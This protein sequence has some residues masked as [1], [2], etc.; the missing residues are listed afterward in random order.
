LHDVEKGDANPKGFP[1]DQFEVQEIVSGIAPTVELVVIVADERGFHDIG[2]LIEVFLIGLHLAAV[3]AEL[4]VVGVGGKEV[5]VGEGIGILFLQI[6]GDFAELGELSGV[7]F[8]GEVIG[9]KCGMI[10]D[11]VDQSIELC[12]RIGVIEGIEAGDDRMKKQRAEAVF[13]GDVQFVLAAPDEIPSAFR[14]A[15]RG[16]VIERGDSGKSWAAPVGGDRCAEAP[17][18]GC[19]GA[20]RFCQG[21]SGEQ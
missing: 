14:Q 10:F 9:V 21:G 15:I 3:R 8:I 16:R 1:A 6:G 13:R 18:F 4:L 17:C 12:F 20:F 19:L 5:D 2:V 11:P 7:R